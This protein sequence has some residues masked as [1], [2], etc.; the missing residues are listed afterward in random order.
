M[1]WISFALFS[2][3]IFPSF[4]LSLCVFLHLLATGSHDSKVKLDHQIQKRICKLKSE[5]GDIVVRA[6]RWLK[7]RYPDAQ[8][9]AVWLNETLRGL[10]SEP[11]AIEDDIG[12]HDALW[13]ILQTKW[14]FT[15]S[16]FL[17]GLVE[18]SRDAGL[19]ERMC[20]YNEGFKFVRRSIPISN[21][22]V[23]FE[24]YDPNKPCL[25]L[26]FESITYFNDI[27]I[28]LDDVFH[29]YRRY[30]RVHKIKPGCVEVILQFP[31]S[32]EP[33][34]QACIDKKHKSVEH[35]TKMRI[36]SNKKQLKSPMSII[37]RD[38][39]S[40]QITP[41]EEETREQ[42]HWCVDRREHINYKKSWSRSHSYAGTQSPVHYIGPKSRKRANTT[43]ASSKEELCKRTKQLHI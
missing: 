13:K 16:R 39:K 22:E 20:N 10:P 35:Y 27:E 7:Y 33:L 31:A 24:D 8:D 4:P 14:S 36:E 34:L 32:M 3:I 17:Q 38:L 28:F 5:F 2:T 29:I 42:V 9:A 37:S 23:A 21:Q 41:I 1:N 26:I 18:S 11:L 25:I 6:L 15:N 30:L 19:I 43:D 12:N 40:K